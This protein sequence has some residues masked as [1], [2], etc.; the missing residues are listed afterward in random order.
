LEQLE[1]TSPFISKAKQ[2]GLHE[3]EAESKG[4]NETLGLEAVWRKI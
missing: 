1:N 2:L 4:L 3:H